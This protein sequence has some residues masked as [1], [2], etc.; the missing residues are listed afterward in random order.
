MSSSEKHFSI[1]ALN[2]MTDLHL[3]LDG[4]ISPQSARVLAQMQGI[5]LSEDDD[6]LLSMLSLPGNCSDLDEFLSVFAFPCSL[7]RTKG[8]I[9]CAVE[10]L[11]RELK[12]QGVMYAEIR[13]APQI[14][15]SQTMTQEQ[16]VLAAIEG[17]RGRAISA[18][19]ILCCMRGANNSA[20]NR[21]TA[22]LAAK[23][24]GKGVAAL[25]L[26]GSEA[27]FPI[28]DFHGIFSFA[29]EK[30]VPFTIHA[31]EAAGAQNVWA[32]LAFGA[33]RIGHG[34]RAGED[35]ALL[36]ELA[37]RNIPLEMCP[38]SNLMTASVSSLAEWPLRTYLDAGIAVTINT[39]DPAIERTNI[40]REFRLLADAFALSKEEIRQLLR[41]SVRASFADD[42]LKEALLQKIDD[43]FAAVCKK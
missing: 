33:S 15:T 24:F 16:A 13:F 40:K 22:E 27:A 3:H 6:K 28:E 26:A 14:L 11:L 30:G 25:D 36:A 42:A 1:D 38:T 35:P 31:G 32:A 23:Y 12:S 10:T 5:A 34:I 9:R 2:C 19:L 4:A 7:L 37:K 29:R 39:D 17:M 43:N 41:N 8:A 21:E 18:N 20:Q